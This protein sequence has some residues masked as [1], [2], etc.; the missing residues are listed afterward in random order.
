MPD[1]PTGPWPLPLPSGEEPPIPPPSVWSTGQRDIAAQLR[2][3]G[4]VA[5]SETD[6]DLIPPAIAAH[7]IAMY[8]HPGELILDPDC[9]TGTVL[10]EAL[11]AGRHALGLTTQQRSWTTARANV[12]AT[13]AAGAWR[14]GSV[15][16]ARP[17][18]LAGI[19][20]AGLVGRVGLVLTALRTPTVHPTRSPDRDPDRR[21]DTALDTALADLAAT[22]SYSEPLLR[23]GGHMVVVARPRRHTDGSLVDMPARLITAAASAGLVPVERCVALTAKLRGGRIVTRASLAERRAAARAHGAPVALTA[24]REVLVF[25]LGHDAELAAAAANSTVPDQPDVPRQRTHHDTTT[26][27]SD[28]ADDPDRRRAA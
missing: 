11:R 1:R 28:A 25:Q 5:G 18:V 2:I 24:H 7:A 10:V 16:D 3:S 9:G 20:A 23:A 8:T 21:V 22:M 4:T 12:T 19:R 6:P 14:D 15:L 17:N 13:K 27:T 26:G